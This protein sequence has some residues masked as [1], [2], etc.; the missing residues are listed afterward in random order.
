VFEGYCHILTVPSHIEMASIKKIVT[1]VLEESDTHYYALLPFA[2][3][4]IHIK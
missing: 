3:V 1:K 4:D 2:V